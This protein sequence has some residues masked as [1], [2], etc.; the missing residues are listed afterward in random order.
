MY[1]LLVSPLPMHIINSTVHINE[2]TNIQRN[3]TMQSRFDNWNIVAEF[4]NALYIRI[5]KKDTKLNLPN[6]YAMANI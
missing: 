4:L 3:N 6:E 5:T 1:G 2:M